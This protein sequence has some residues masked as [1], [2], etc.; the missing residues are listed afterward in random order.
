MEQWLEQEIPQLVHQGGFEPKQSSTSGGLS[1]IE[2]H[3]ASD[4]LLEGKEGNVLF[5]DALNTFY[6]R[7]VA[8][9]I[10]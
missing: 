7:Y 8:S 4:R 10:S 2:L 6:L 1:T 9:D 3:L 5:N